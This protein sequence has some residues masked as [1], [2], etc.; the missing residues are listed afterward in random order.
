MGLTDMQGLF[1]NIFE[2]RI[3]NLDFSAGHSPSPLYA[4]HLSKWACQIL[5]QVDYSVCLVLLTV[6]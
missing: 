3:F 6:L 4:G 1:G 5:L 2:I